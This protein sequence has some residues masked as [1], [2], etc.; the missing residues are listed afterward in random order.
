VDVPGDPAARAAADR[1]R[2][3]PAPH[4]APAEVR[5]ALRTRLTELAQAVRALRS[6][7]GTDP[8]RRLLPGTR[9][10]AA[11]EVGEAAW[12]EHQLRQSER[13]L[14]SAGGCGTCH[15]L[16][17]SSA[18][19]PEVAVPQPVRSGPPR[20]KFQHDAHRFLRC[21]E[22]HPAPASRSQVDLLLP[23]VAV[24]QACHNPQVGVRSECVDCHRYHGRAHAVDWM[25]T[26]TL[27]EFR[28]GGRP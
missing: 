11:A 8:D 23:R 2:R 22:C 12:V 6:P 9:P 16:G 24:C 18:D 4:R 5:T 19:L 21:T 27:D 14:F 10:A 20:A 7:P 28:R 17:S 25:G 1:Y 13:L 15:P 26:M 3:E